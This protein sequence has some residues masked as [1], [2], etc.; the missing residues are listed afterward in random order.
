MW[1]ADGAHASA[2]AAIRERMTTICAHVPA[3]EG[4]ALTSCRGFLADAG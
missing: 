3:T 1:N 2:I 4:T